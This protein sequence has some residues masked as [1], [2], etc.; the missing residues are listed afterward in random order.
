MEQLKYKDFVFL[1]ILEQQGGGKNGEKIL[2]I[3]YKLNFSNVAHG[4][5]K[6]YSIHWTYLDINGKIRRSNH[7]FNNLEEVEAFFYFLTQFKDGKA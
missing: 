2:A 3:N 1:P 4:G 7:I 5:P 6:S